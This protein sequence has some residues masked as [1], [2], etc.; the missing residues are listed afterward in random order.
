[1]YRRHLKRTRRR[2]ASPRS[3]R[4]RLVFWGSALIIGAVAAGFALIAH[5]ADGFYRQLHTSDPW[6]AYALT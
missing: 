6:L 5:H 1:M 2:L 3:W 4:L